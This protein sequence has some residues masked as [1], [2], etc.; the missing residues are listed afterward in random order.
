MHYN[1]TIIVYVALIGGMLD[2]IGLSLLILY[3]KNWTRPLLVCC[4]IDIL[5]ELGTVLVGGT[6]ETL[7]WRPE[8]GADTWNVLT[9][10]LY[11]EG[12]HR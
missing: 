5:R 11:R 6:A 10:L 8:V 2:G 3:R 1:V 7:L 4:F 12:M 9:K